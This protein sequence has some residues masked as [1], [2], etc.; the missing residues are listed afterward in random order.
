[1]DINLFDKL[2]SFITEINTTNKTNEKKEILSKYPELKEILKYVYDKNIVFSVKS[3]NYLKFEKNDKKK[4]QTTIFKYKSIYDLLNDLHLRK[5]TGD[6]ALL[7][8][9]QFIK[10]NQE[11]KTLILNIIDKNLKIGINTKVINSVFKDLVKTFQVVLANKYDK[12]HIKENTEWYISRKLDGVRCIIHIDIDKK[13]VLF[14]SRQGKQFNTLNKIKCSIMKNIHL[15]NES[16][17]FDGEVV[18]MV[19]N[20]ENFKGI[21]E[22]IKRKNHTIENPLFYCFD[23]IQMSE[24][25]KLQSDI[26][27]SNRIEKLM[28]IIDNFEYIKYL[29]QVKYTDESFN[30]MIQKSS[31]NDWEG[32]ILRKNEKYAGKR[33][34]DLLKYKVFHD[35]EYKVVDIITGPFRMINKESGLEEEIETMSAVIIDY[36]DTKVGSGFSIDERKEYYNDPSK[37]IGKIITVKYFEK[38]ES[39]L[40][41]PIFKYIHG[42]K[43]NL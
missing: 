19:D 24:F 12:K 29:E 32:L 38:T 15:F 43:R 42:K 30:N 40:R 21:M 2:Q 22:E 7:Y 25:Y 26:I 41:F 27:F 14:F 34:N 16:C 23:M 33:T 36:N 39:S 17:I 13:E 10:D 11:H 20:K 35:E 8:L 28:N 6:T 9:Y 37:I 4:K 18:S 5:I 31:N 1:M 3:K